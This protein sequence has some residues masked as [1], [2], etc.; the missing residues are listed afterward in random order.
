MKSI[1]LFKTL[2]IPDHIHF[3]AVE[4][5]TILGFKR[6]PVPFT[7]LNN[8]HERI[9]WVDSDHSCGE[10]LMTDC[11]LDDNLVHGVAWMKR[12]TRFKLVRYEEYF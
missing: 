8:G 4:G 11:E 10:P 1:E 6:K 9:L 2:I 12:G 3:I 5:R 7:S